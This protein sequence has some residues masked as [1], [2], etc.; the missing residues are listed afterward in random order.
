M[1]LTSR[2]GRRPVCTT[3][4]PATGYV[5]GDNAH[6]RDQHRH[7]SAAYD[8]VTTARL[9]ATG[10]TDGWQCLDIGAGDGSVAIWLAD[11]VA[12][13]GSVL[14][15]DLRPHRM[16]SRAEL[17]VVAHDAAIDPL[18]ECEFDLINARLVLRHLPSREK[19]LGKLAAALRPGGW[20]QIDE[21]DTSYEP[22]LLCADEESRRLYE[23]FLAAK[24][25]VMRAAGV[26]ESWGRD[27]AAAMRAAGLT[28][29][30]PQPYIGVRRA[31]S[32]D[33]QLLI[34][35]TF[36]LRDAL[37]AAG[38]SE[39][40]LADVREVM[41]HPEFLATS[42]VLYSVQGRRPPIGLSR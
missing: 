25:E 19:V 27:V 22:P 42:C 33:L 29:I 11:R 17:T 23:R 1:D 4:L 12:P 31:G 14:A 24:S 7:L 3:D 28:G 32:P 10:V 5:F 20:L 34:N 40:D 37:V 39:Q 18:P 2:G 41:R 13:S 15:T 30:D 26:A 16:P 6:S 9:A 8:P 35:H 36:H 38:M 21:F